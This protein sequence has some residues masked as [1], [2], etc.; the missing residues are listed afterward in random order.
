MS[1]LIA[2]FSEA[3]GA[4][5]DVA[6]AWL[7]A[8]KFHLEAAVGAYYGMASAGEDAAPAGKSQLN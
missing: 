8:H 5:T 4:R 1:N 2:K 7:A 3:T 6:R